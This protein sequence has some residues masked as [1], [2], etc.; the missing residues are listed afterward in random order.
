VLP[1]VAF[2]CADNSNGF[3]DN[4][5]N[6]TGVRDQNTAFIDRFSYTFNFEYL[7]AKHEAK[8]ISSR[9]GLS[10]DASAQIVQFANVAREK[11]KSGLLTQPPSLRQL[12]AW[13][14]AV[15]SG[16][17]VTAA[18]QSAVI[19]K[20]PADCEAELK[21]IFTAVINVPKFKLSVGS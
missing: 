11:S 7:P 4:S 3:G 16:I 12:L 18:Y 1:Y 2:F 5:G 10:K 13:A 6:F 17:P 8:L 20:Y 21:G 19:N 9:T 15:K 14:T